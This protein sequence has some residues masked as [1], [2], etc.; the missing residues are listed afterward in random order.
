MGKACSRRGREA[1]G[2][3]TLI[4]TLEGKRPLGIYGQRWENYEMV[5]KETQLEM[6]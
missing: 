3:Q 2:I 6:C 1:K 4:G 5:L